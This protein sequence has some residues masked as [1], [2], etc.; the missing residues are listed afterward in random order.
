MAN[1]QAIIMAGGAGS[2]H[3]IPPGEAEAVAR[4][5]AVAAVDRY[6]TVPFTFRGQAATLATGDLQ[7]LAERGHLPVIQ[8]GGSA[9][10]LGRIHRDGLADPGAV[11]SDEG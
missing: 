8:G 6:Q 1:L 4:D 11:A 2:R 3:R 5:S 7:V 9:E 10:V